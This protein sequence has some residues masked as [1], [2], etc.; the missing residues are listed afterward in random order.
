MPRIAISVP[1]CF[2]YECCGSSGWTLW[3]S[4]VAHVRLCLCCTCGLC[5][6]VPFFRINSVSVASWH[7]PAASPQGRRKLPDPEGA[8]AG[9]DFLRYQN[10]RNPKSSLGKSPLFLWEGRAHP[11]IHGCRRG[12]RGHHR[13]RVAQ[14]VVKA[15]RRQLH[16]D[17][18]QEDM[19]SPHFQ[20]GT[21]DPSP[22]VCHPQG[23]RGD[24]QIRSCT[25][26]THGKR[27]DQHP[28]R[29]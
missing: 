17:V 1:T 12:L 5:P 3:F 20:R 6:C 21:H 25:S 22:A 7:L 23:V 29:S 14:A 13:R 9:V 24:C 16:Q 26:G 28:S 15:L 11:W 27:R 19:G 10:L 18:Y 4:V 2:L 8:L